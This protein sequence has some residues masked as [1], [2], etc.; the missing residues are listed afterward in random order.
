[1][2]VLGDHVVGDVRVPLVAHEYSH[3][4][5]VRDAI[6]HDAS[7]AMIPNPDAGL[8]FPHRVDMTAVNDESAHLD[9]D[10]CAFPPSTAFDREGAD[11]ADPT[12]R[13]VGEGTRGGR[14]KVCCGVRIHDTYA[15]DLQRLVDDDVLGVRTRT[16]EDH[17]VRIRRRDG[18]GDG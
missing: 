17:V 2:L 8:H 10:R 11:P 6:A 5:A 4:T 13:S 14:P 7:K 16:D 12:R 18:R 9:V 15:D 1:M 3:A